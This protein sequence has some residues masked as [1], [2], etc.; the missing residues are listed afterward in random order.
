MMKK[1]HL[2]ILKYQTY[3]MFS[4]QRWR[5]QEKHEWLNESFTS[6]TYFTLKALQK[7]KAHSDLRNSLCKAQ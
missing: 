4:V 3:L 7:L 5:Q 6:A 1:N 2:Y